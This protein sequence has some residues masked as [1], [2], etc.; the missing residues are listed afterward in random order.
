MIDTRS[1]R[2]TKASA[3]RASMRQG[4]KMESAALMAF[5]V[6]EPSDGGQS[7]TT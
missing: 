7:I 5:S 6:K 2:S 4:I 1:R 3:V